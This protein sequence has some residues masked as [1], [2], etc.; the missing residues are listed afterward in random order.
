MVVDVSSD[1]KTFNEIV[2]TE[3]SSSEATAFLFEGLTTVDPFTLK[4]IPN[5]ASSWD[6]S[7]DGLQWVFHLRG[8]V[9]FF[10]GVALTADDVVFTF[11]D[12]IYNTDIPSSARDI[13]TIEGNIFKVEKLDTLTVRFTLPVKFAPFL[14]SMSQPI[15]PK[16]CLLESVV[17]KRF[18]FTWGIN[19][20]T[21][22]IIGTGPFY[23]DQ[24][25]P[26]ERLVF[27]R[28]P[29]YWKKDKEGRPL[30]KLNKVIMLI[31][32]DPSTSL[33]KFIDGELDIIGVR[34]QDYPL[35]KP[36]ELKKN[37][38]IFHIIHI[39]SSILY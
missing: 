7:P 28:N 25:F 10:D 11:N 22:D 16:H 37:F 17:L 20:K 24:Y 1:P 35:L 13:F 30:P 27:K 8:D 38:K 9:K 33:L 3:S 19:T 15:L 39:F 21:K 23:L 18:P 4:I 32:A 34:G 36:I 6:V 12:L 14:R 5:L 31:V 26:G 29:L 2:S